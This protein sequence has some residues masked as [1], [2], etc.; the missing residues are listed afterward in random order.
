MF[1]IKNDKI[2]LTRGD[3]GKIECVLRDGAGEPYEMQDGDVLTL[4]VRDV[5]SADSPVMLQVSSITKLLTIDH[6]DTADLPV[7]EY[8][9]DIQ[10]TTADGKRL[11]F[12]PKLD[13]IKYA[14]EKNF[15][16]FIIMPE[17]T[18]V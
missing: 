7:G 11:T 18:R 2:R 10:L 9:A 15:K 13:E 17:V 4:T 3:Y 14:R 6:A 8:S 5:A 12:W 1:E 16:N